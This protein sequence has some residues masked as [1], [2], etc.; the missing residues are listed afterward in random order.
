MDVFISGALGGLGVCLTREF[1]KKGNRVFAG[2]LTPEHIAELEEV[3]ENKNLIIVPLNVSQKESIEA[4]KNAIKS[5]TDKLDVLINVA[6][7]LL[8][9]ENYILTD[10]YED[11]E[12]T[13]KI[14]TIGPIYIINAFFDLLKKSNN[15]TII[16]ISSE[17]ISIDDVGSK[18][19]AYCMSKT[20]IA[21]YGFILKETLKEI[22]IP[23]RVFSVHPGRMKTVMGAENGQIKPEE[24]AEGIYKIAVGKVLP[25]NEEVYINY[26]GEPML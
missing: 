12:L 11:I 25:Q 14:N 3:R 21:Q 18:F 19:G 8:N 16:N 23:M 1:L 4:A 26:K 22:N 6:G 7:V 20:A 24:S 17:V 9:R 5:H 13:F 10:Q 2:V 15:A